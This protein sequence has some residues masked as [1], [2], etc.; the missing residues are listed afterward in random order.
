LT[1]AIDSAHV[2]LLVFA[3]WFLACSKSIA[4]SNLKVPEIVLTIAA[5]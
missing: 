3:V 4:G 2:I 5:D 1:F